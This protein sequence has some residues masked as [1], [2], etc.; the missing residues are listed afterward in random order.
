MMAGF[1]AQQLQQWTGGQ[2][3]SPSQDAACTGLSIDSRTLTSGQAFLA[4]SGD[5]FDGHEYTSMAHQKGAALLIVERPMATDLPELLV[6][7]SRQAL[8][9][10][11]AGYRGQF[12]MPLVS[13]TG[14]AGKTSCKEMLLL[15]LAEV[16]PTLATQGNLNNDIGVPLTL[17]RLTQDHGFAV[18]EHGAN[19]LGEIAQT[20]AAAKPSVALLLNARDAHLGEFGSRDAIIRAKGEIFSSLSPQG[21]A[22]LPLDNPGL[23]H[24]QQVLVGHPHAVS[25]SLQNDR[26]DYYLSALQLASF[27]GEA[28]FHYP[29]GQ[30][31]LRLQ[32]PGEHNLYNA[33]AALAVIHILGLPV[34]AAAQ[35][36]SAYQGTAGRLQKNQFAHACLIDD[37]YNASPQSVAAAIDVLSHQSGVRLMV[38]A[39]MAELGAESADIHAQL[40]LYAQTRIDRLFTLGEHSQ[41]MAQAFGARSQHFTSREALQAAILALPPAPLTLLIKGSHSSGIYQLASTLRDIWGQQ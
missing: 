1:T 9:D 14:S 18:I 36:L 7:C 2:W 39:D 29:G 5:R 31:Q 12:A 4:L 37:S 3:G 23:T 21:T 25:F 30:C 27:S 19:H 34:A 17:L 22:L 33:C 16:A 35:A 13:L 6:P 10:I 38:M 15:M 28:S 32:V 24:W 41:H 8:L 40:G 11:A 20:V 26:A